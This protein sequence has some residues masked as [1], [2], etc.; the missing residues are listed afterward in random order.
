V[1][2]GDLHDL[3]AQG[4]AHVDVAGARVSRWCSRRS[5]RAATQPR[6]SSGRVTAVV[7]IVCFWVRPPSSTTSSGPLGR[8]VGVDQ[9]LVAGLDA[10]EALGPDPRRAGHAD[11]DP[12]ARGAGQ[13]A[14][15]LLGRDAF[16][17]DGSVAR[18]AAGHQRAQAR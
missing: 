1:A 8:Q 4:R 3:L 13:P 16:V 2:D 6:S 17:E 11:L 5:M 12:R 10:V 15:G 14:R 9:R 18:Q 7:G